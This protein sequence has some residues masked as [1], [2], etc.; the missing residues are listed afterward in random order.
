M[1]ARTGTFEVSPERIDD[2]VR[3][4]EEEQIP[5]YREQQG[6]KGFTVLGKTR[7]A[8]RTLLAKPYAR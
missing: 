4:L 6:Y 7:D 5:R 3:R 2:V 8:R 1:H